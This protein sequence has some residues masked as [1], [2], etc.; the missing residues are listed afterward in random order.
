MITQAAI[1]GDLVEMRELFITN[2][3]KT[4]QESRGGHPLL[5]AAFFG[6]AD[7]VRELLSQGW[8]STIKMQRAPMH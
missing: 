5:L 4:I 2:T 1:D 8:M 3:E 6:H 7:I